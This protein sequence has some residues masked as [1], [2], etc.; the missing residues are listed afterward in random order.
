LEDLRRERRLLQEKAKRIS[1]AIA[2]AGHSPTLLSSLAGLER[3]IAEI[4]SRIEAHRPLDLA[5]EVGEIRE[6]VYSNVTHLKGLLRGDV[7]KAKASLARHLGKLVMTPTQTPF[8]NQG[9]VRKN[10]RWELKG[11]TITFRWSSGDPAQE[12]CQVG[13]VAGSLNMSCNG[14]VTSFGRQ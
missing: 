6:F 1:E 2:E 7:A 9:V 3:K 4:D 11:N 5:A 8:Y 10:G 13:I 12:Q 14:D